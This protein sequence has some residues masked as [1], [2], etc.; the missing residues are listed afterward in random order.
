MT[1]EQLLFSYLPNEDYSDD[2]DS[3]LAW[4]HP[5]GNQNRPPS[6]RLKNSIR[7]LSGIQDT[8][9]AELLIS[10]YMNVVRREYLTVIDSMKEGKVVK[11]KDIISL[12]NKLAYPCSFIEGLDQQFSSTINTLRHYAVDNSEP[13]REMLI[14]G[15]RAL[16]MNDDLDLVD[17][18]LKWIN[19]SHAASISSKDIILD[20]MVEKIAAM[21]REK[22]SGKWTN[23]YL[24]MEVF[25]LFIKTY[26]SQFSKLI[27]CP[28]DNHS[29]TTTVHECFED[30]FI[31]IR[32]EEIYRIVIESYPTSIPT[33]LELKKVLRSNRHKTRN[34]SRIMQ[35]FLNEFESQVLNPG[36]ATVDIL[37]A[38]IRSMRCFLLLDSS[39]RYVS[40][41]KI[42]VKSYFKTRKDMISILLWAVLDL[43]EQEFKDLGIE[44]VKDI[45]KLSAELSAENDPES[46]MARKIDQIYDAQFTSP[47]QFS[48]SGNAAEQVFQDPLV[49]QAVLR[50]FLSWVPEP[51]SY[52]ENPNSASNVAGGSGGDAPDGNT[53]I[54]SIP[55]EVGSGAPVAN[56][57]YFL[58]L[59][60]DSPE[61]KTRF[62]TDFMTILT[63][64]LMTLTAYRLDSK[65]ASCLWFIRRKYSQKESDALLG[66]RGVTDLA[67]DGE[68]E[69]NV[70]A[71]IE[72]FAY[73]LNKI[74]VMLH[75]MR[76]SE[77]L[78]R[79]IQQQRVSNPIQPGSDIE[80]FPKFI[81][82]TYWE[83]EDAG[84][85]E[86]VDS[87]LAN[88]KYHYAPVLED[89][90]LQSAYQFSRA[91]EHKALHLCRDAGAMEV[92][93][94]L[95]EGTAH[96][97]TLL[98]TVTVP[99]YC[100]IQAFSSGSS[101]QPEA[102]T[103]EELA[104]RSGVPAAELPAILQFWVSKHVLLFDIHSGKYTT[105][106]SGPQ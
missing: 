91:E 100:V 93:L 22:M 89:R 41:L 37:L 61:S 97:V 60:L 15:M 58:D 67:D 96:P 59:L 38:Y 80:V 6:L 106:E 95:G 13:V 45:E 104:A 82:P 43:H 49:Y 101:H 94:Q 75:D 65:W 36:V 74:D 53:S 5:K 33:I 20:L 87:K 84:P 78:C 46:S 81:S 4:L 44:Y 90:I 63:K 18:Y 56:K 23:R 72:G 57:S 70:A 88:N 7:R 31:K 103:A 92:E 34:F 12:E 17:G 9:F 48:P 85:E 2:L 27:G 26:W 35:T 50:Q 24:V 25:N 40:P 16:I 99:Q 76:T 64:K 10:Y 19:A 28:E 62:I 11:F 105:N 77:V 42:Y 3:I 86:A 47:R 73:T 68:S 8:H 79:Q 51:T 29:L 66:N 54:S 102:L 83:P 14:N 71:D 30:L 39:G 69:H 1:T 21:C 32:T 52:S 98:L 55:E